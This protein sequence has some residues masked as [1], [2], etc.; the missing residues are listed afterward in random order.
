LRKIL[1]FKFGFIFGVVNFDLLMM[2]FMREESMHAREGRRGEL[3]LT[4][5]KNKLLIRNK[6]L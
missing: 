2:G 4:G 1:N 5:E 3:A 6:E